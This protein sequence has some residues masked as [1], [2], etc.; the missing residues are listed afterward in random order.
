MFP[1]VTVS[2]AGRGMCADDTGNTLIEV[3][4]ANLVPLREKGDLL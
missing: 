2:A 1:S 4:P 3:L